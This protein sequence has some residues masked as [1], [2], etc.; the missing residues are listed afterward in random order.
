MIAKWCTSHHP[1]LWS[2]NMSKCK[3]MTL[4]RSI[5]RAQYVQWPELINSF[6]VENDRKNRNFMKLPKQVSCLISEFAEESY[7]TDPGWSKGPGLCHNL[8]QLQPLGCCHKPRQNPEGK[9]QK[10]SSPVN[11]G[12][13][14]YQP[15][16]QGLKM[17]P[18]R[19]VQSF[20]CHYKELSLDISKPNMTMV[21]LNKLLLTT[22][23]MSTPVL[24]RCSTMSIICL[25][26][27]AEAPATRF[28]DLQRALWCIT[29]VI[30][31]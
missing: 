26:H 21:G 11:R 1:T 8:F 25:H 14:F 23:Q 20:F 30:L 18:N 10:P 22:K 28:C 31:P 29:Q 5:A 19:L 12:M 17:L 7:S 24:S 16:S 27:C 6:L 13:L 15:P 4:E 2:C 3:L 9:W